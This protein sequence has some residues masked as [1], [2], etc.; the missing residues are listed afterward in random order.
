[1]QSVDSGVFSLL[2]CFSTSDASFLSASVGGSFAASQLSHLSVLPGHPLSFCS[3]LTLSPDEPGGGG[4]RNA[5]VLEV[6]PV[7][8]SYPLARWEGDLA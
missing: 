4:L 7:V 3:S 5:A 1:M 6:C 8:L 2:S